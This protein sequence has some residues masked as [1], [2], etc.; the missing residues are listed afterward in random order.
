M[1]AQPPQPPERQPPEP[2]PPA[3]NPP[4]FDRQPTIP[5]HDWRF[6]PRRFPQH[7][8]PHYAPPNHPL[9]PWMSS[10]RHKRRWLV[11]RMFFFLLPL[12]LCTLATA[13]LLALLGLLQAPE[14]APPLWEMTLLACGLPL[15][16][17]LILLLVGAWVF[18]SFGRPL[19]SVMSAADTVAAG[20]LSVRLDEN[21][22]GEMGR[23]ARSFNRMTAELKRSEQ[24]RRSL[25]AD[26]AHELRTPLHIL[27]GNLEGVLDGVYEPTP[28]HIRATL[29]EARLLRRLVDDLQT[30]SLAE[31]GQL[32]LHRQVVSAAD[33]L[34]DAQTSFSGP[35]AAVHVSLAVE[36]QGSPDELTVEVDPDRI[37][38]ALTNLV[39]NALRHTPPGGKITL[40]ALPLEGGV[41]LQVQ[42]SGPGIAPEDLPFIFDR[43]W[44]SDRA[45]TR[46][47]PQE[48][49]SQPDLEDDATS[50]SGLGLA[51]ARQL[52]RAHG[53]D[54]QA[55]SPARPGG[56]LHA[57]P[58]G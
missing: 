27:Q 58:A 51:I 43:F 29:D 31:A 15:G 3:A 56:A 46:P 26:V 13:F 42:D 32:P 18:R 48:P 49:E 28:E 23:L 36:L 7:A 4:A 55:A 37:D 39:A 16:F 1:S 8:A 10:E 2:L 52:A 57:R 20:D 22:P 34:A 33:L 5:T 12:V 17:G 50:H 40:R 30:L 11:G 53:G 47:E 38:Q 19:A 24:A 6:P 45:R 14:S 54:L 21:V 25:T 9:P 35:A 41:R 44:K